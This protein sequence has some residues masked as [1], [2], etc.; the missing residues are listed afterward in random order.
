MEYLVVTFVA[1]LASTLTLFSGF[2]LGTL[3]MPAIAVFFSVELAVAMT[4]VV[5]LANNLF[6]LGLLARHADRQAV[7][8]FG[9]PALATA[10]LGAW[11]L[12]QLSAGERFV[13]YAFG[14]W[15]FSVEAVSFIIGC[16]ILVFVV[17][18]LTPAFGRLAFDRRWLPLGGA[19]SGFFGG[20]SGHQGAFRSMFLIKS[21]LSKEAFVATG[22]VLAVMVDVARMLVYG[23]SL[24]AYA[25]DINWLLVAL[26]TL[27]AFLGAFIG[28]RLVKKVTLQW[29]QWMVS[30]CL[31]MIGLGMVTGNI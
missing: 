28:A 16:V 25:A 9:L 21:G 20:L 27:A 13:E 7:L 18:E 24:N 10:F 15:A 29:V 1:F 11:W 12:G 5:H 6:K 4:A 19:L 30:A 2:G 22:V 17:L 23:V 14:G 3:L 8:R 26:A 31:L